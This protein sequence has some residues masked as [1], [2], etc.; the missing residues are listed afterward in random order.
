V[1][2]ATWCA[3]VAFGALLGACNGAP[4]PSQFPSAV[5]ALARMKKTYA[6][7]NGIQGDGKIDHLGTEG[8]V[9]GEVLLFAINPARVRVDVI[10]PFGALLFLLT[11]NG[12]DFKM[13]DAKEKQFLHGPAKACNLAR[14]TQVPLPGHVLVSILRGEAPLLVHEP[15]APTIEWDGD[16]YRVLIPSKHEAEQELHLQVYEDDWLKPWEQQRIRVTQS[17][18][19]QRGHTIYSAEMT[20]HAMASTAAARVDPDGLDPDILP[21]G[22]ACDVEVPRSIR[23][24]VPSKGDD[25]IFQYE[26]VSLNPPIPVGIF[27]QQAPEGINRRFVDCAED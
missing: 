25:V 15:Q 11:S 10:S 17:N 16:H 24:L 27:A 23:M 8:R 22:G 14:M 1:R 5:D 9:R 21:S 4:P 6:C 2:L 19:Y 7:A 18:I 26:E 3:A 20:N 13:L 12:T